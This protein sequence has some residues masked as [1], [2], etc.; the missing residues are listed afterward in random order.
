MIVWITGLPAAGKTTLAE[1]LASCF[2]NDGRPV[3]ILDGD[4][5]REILHTE[6]TWSYLDRRDNCIRIARMARLI[7]ESNVDVI[8]ATVSWFEHVRPNLATCKVL[9]VYVDTPRE[10][11]ERR[12]PKHVYRDGKFTQEYIPIEDPDYTLRG[13]GDP[14]MTAR[15]LYDFLIVTA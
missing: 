10:L 14:A 1:K 4:R 2:R 8:V 9:T 6:L 13:T 7:S 5:V 15:T 11:C 12:D 3:V